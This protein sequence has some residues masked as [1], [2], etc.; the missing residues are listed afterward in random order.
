MAETNSW[1]KEHTEEGNFKKWGQND[2]VYA[3]R[4]QSSDFEVNFKYWIEI[5]MG[6]NNPKEIPSPRAQEHE[7]L[8]DSE[9]LQ[10]VLTDWRIH[11][12]GEAGPRSK[13]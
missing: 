8:Y 13:I 1:C 6:K 5:F 4:L 10:V 2:S 7:S 12:W 3:E 9:K 11:L